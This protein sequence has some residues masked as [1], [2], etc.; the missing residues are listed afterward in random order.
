M[1]QYTIAKKSH[2]FTAHI[3]EVHM[4]TQRLITKGIQN[5]FVAKFE[6]IPFIVFIAFLFTFV[7]TRL[8]VYIS[9]KDIPNLSFLIDRTIVNGI[10]IHHFNFGIIL[11]AIVGFQGLY[12]IS[13]LYHRRLAVLYGIAL[14]L[15]FDEFAMWLKL[16]DQYN[17]RIT[18]NAI[19]VICL[20]FLNIIYFPHYWKKMGSRVKKNILL[21]KSLPERMRTFRD[22][23]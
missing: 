11:L 20:I 22:K 6:E 15:T 12:D 13:R 17:S 14:A 5:I 7:L 18:Y 3:K 2:M 16:E 10:H 1:V 23:S 19:V 21:I 8:Y 9:Y 4:R